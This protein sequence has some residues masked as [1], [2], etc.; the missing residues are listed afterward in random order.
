M[1][2]ELK[3]IKYAA[4][5]S[6]ET[7]CFEAAVYIDGKKCAHVSNDGRGGSDNWHEYVK[8]TQDRLDKYA[9]ETMQPDTSY[10]IT[11]EPDAEILVGHLLDRWQALREMH[12]ALRRR[13]MFTKPG[14]HGIYQT[15]PMT[16]GQM[17]MYLNPGNL[18]RFKEKLGA[19]TIFN[20]LP[21]GEAL[22]LWLKHT[23]PE[24]KPGNG[25]PPAVPEVK[26][27]ASA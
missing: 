27:A 7:P 15:K 13:V 5:A 12:R 3:N 21:E 17:Q 2:V 26:E 19:E 6:E 11:I 1:K 18:L 24:P 22:I 9:K 10:G 23:A 14:K 25:I 8:G 16:P 20:A 4:F